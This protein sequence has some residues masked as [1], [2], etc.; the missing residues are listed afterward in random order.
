MRN[1]SVVAIGPLKTHSGT[2]MVYVKEL[3]LLILSQTEEPAK[4]GTCA[5]EE[6]ALNA[7]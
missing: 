2:G 1:K 4:V 3:L 6:R 5:R 7:R